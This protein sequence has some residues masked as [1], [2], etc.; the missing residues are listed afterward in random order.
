MYVPLQYQVSEYDCVPITFVNAIT[1]LFDRQSIPPLVIQ[2]INIYS[3]DTVSRGGKLGRGGTSPYA[4]RLIGNWLNSYKTKTF[5]VSTE[6][7]LEDQIHL[8]EGSP[9]IPCLKEGGV[10][11]CNIYLGH[12]EW[13]Y[14]LALK[15]EEDWMYFFDPYWRQTL[16]GLRG[17]VK[18][19]KSEDGRAPNLAIRLDWLDSHREQQRFCFGETP[20]R[21]CLLMWRQR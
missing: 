1:Y 3:L 5:S 13:H 17:I 6:Y 15:V 14:I 8:Q 2:R 18:I 4:I 16:R 7:L 9:I 12:R 21:E 19:L 20:D 10:A 11:L